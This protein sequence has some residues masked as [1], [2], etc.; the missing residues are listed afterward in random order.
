ML[1]PSIL[2][3]NHGRNPELQSRVVLQW[4]SGNTGFK[5]VPR[6]HKDN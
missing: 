5:R 3:I 2:H 4:I 1:S 6:I